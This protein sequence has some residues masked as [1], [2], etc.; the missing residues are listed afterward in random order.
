MNDSN[1]P[2]RNIYYMLTYAYKSFKIEGYQS[3]SSEKFEHLSDL[4]GEIL[5]LTIADLV[6][7]GLWK[8]YKRKAESS[9]VIRGKINLNESLKDNSILKK[10]LVVEY[11]I[12]SENILFNQIIKSTMLRLV[13]HSEIEKEHKKR[14]RD[15]LLYFS[16]VDEIPLSLD[17]WKSIR[18]NPQNLH[19]QLTLD[20]CRYLFERMLLDE[21]NQEVSQKQTKDEQQ[22]S[23]LFEKFVY[24]FYVRETDYHVSHPRIYWEVDDGMD[25][26]LPIMQ[27]DI[28]LKRKNHTFIIDTKFYNHSMARRTENSEYKQ[29]TGNLYQIFAY[30]Q[31]YKKAADEIVSGLLLYAK[32]KDD[33]QPDHCYHIK[34]HKIGVTNLDLS[35]DFNAIKEQLLHFERRL[36]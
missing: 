17:H 18:Y 26:A 11:D 7:R 22:L 15:L 9:S 23:T 36:M 12:L 19:Y 16:E 3:I 21:S 2:I 35:M 33:I 27:T 8:E 10:R 31:N 4:Y 1:I 5:W 6:K 28:V 34:G 24:A 14:L 32:T 13:Y 29:L 20:I 30:V 25:M